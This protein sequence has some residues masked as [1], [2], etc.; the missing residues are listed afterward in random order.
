MQ[1]EPFSLEAAIIA[2]TIVFL[3]LGAFIVMIMLVYRK[4]RNLHIIEKISIQSAFK[5]ELLKTQIEM[6]EQ[7]LS[8]ISREIHDNITQVLSFVKLN[9][10]MLG[11]IN[12]QQKE[13]K[14]TESRELVAQVITDLRDLSK[15]LSF[16]HIKQ[17][18]LSKT[19]TAETERINKSGLIKTELNVEGTPYALGDQRELV[20]FR[21][22]QE[23]LNNTLKHSGAKHLKITLQYIPE[24]F[25][26][27]LEDDG[28]G[29][30]LNASDN[31]S[32]SGLRNMENRAALI[33]AA[34]TITSTPGQGCYIQISLNPLEQH[35]YTDGNYPDSFSR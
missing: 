25:N 34:A 35:L 17:W 24:M 1:Q 33:G 22:F 23:S 7:T 18:G 27:T 3:I 9:L 2:V 19:I 4:R 20:L 21:I 11:D 10:A 31:K 32:G 26:L 29:F 6:Q 16:E 12:E 28:S 5:Q 13:L 14:M 15:S 30:T 8:H